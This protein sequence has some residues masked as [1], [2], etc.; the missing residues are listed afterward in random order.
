MNELTVKLFDTGAAL[1]PVQWNKEEVEAWLEEQVGRYRGRAYNP[2]D[3]K[4]AKKDNDHLLM[5]REEEL[6]VHFQN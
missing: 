2:E 1:P 6:T 5:A 3:M 4:D